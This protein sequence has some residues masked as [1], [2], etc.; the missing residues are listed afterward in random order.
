M[1][2]RS[3]PPKVSKS[4]ANPISTVFKYMNEVKE[5]LKGIE[6]GTLGL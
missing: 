3:D 4:V 1:K 2:S 5:Q 6:E